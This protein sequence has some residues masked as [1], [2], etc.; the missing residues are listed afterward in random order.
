[1]KD[2]HQSFASLRERDYI[3]AIR[4]IAMMK[5]N[6]RILV[7][8][9]HLRVTPFLPLRAKS[10]IAGIFSNELILLDELIEEILSWLPTKI[11]MRFKC[12]S[13][14][15][16]FLISNPYFL[17]LHQE[18]SSLSPLELKLRDEVETYSKM[19]ENHETRLCVFLKNQNYVAAYKE[20]CRYDKCLKAI[21]EGFTFDSLPRGF[22]LARLSGRRSRFSPYGGW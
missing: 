13:K 8:L 11:L 20:S 15:W 21:V 17:K 1:M 4:E 14:K 3:N 7:G 12:V 22:V 18:R 2:V 6:L 19:E 9:S 5:E 16:Y 10:S